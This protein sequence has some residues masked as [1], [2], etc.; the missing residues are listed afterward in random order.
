MA[1]FA[2]VLD[3]LLWV[4]WTVDS[5]ILTHAGLLRTDGVR[6]LHASCG[7]DSNNPAGW[8]LLFV[9]LM[10][11]HLLFCGLGNC[12]HVDRLDVFCCNCGNRL[13]IFDGLDTLLSERCQSLLDN[14][15]DLC[16]HMKRVGWVFEHD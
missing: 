7:S 9:A 1:D 5:S 15:Q 4:P 10:L 8:L 3:L 11:N 13:V 12:L 16:V 6:L 2:E 14:F